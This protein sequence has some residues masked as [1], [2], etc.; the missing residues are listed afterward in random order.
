MWSPSLIEF[1]LHRLPSYLLTVYKNRDFIS[2]Q[3]HCCNF[4]TFC[5]MR[6][7]LFTLQNYSTIFSCANYEKVFFAIET[8]TLCSFL[9]KMW[10]EGVVKVWFIAIYVKM[11]GVPVPLSLWNI[12]IKA[13]FD[14]VTFLP[15]FF[16]A[17]CLN[18]QNLCLFGAKIVIICIPSAVS[19]RNSAP[20]LLLPA[21][22]CLMM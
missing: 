10:E 9:P 17:E 6:L 1:H 5:E 13:S 3:H 2:F 4:F 21:E 14:N 8:A 18:G 19:N 22:A 16:S 12:P 20:Y 15:V 11:V 7:Y